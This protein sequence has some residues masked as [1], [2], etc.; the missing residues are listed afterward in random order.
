VHEGDEP[1]PVA[2]LRDADLLPGKDVTEVDLAALEADPTAVGHHDRL[3]V[4][5]IRQLLEPAIHAG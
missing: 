2:D 3:V 4:K 1:D 5:G